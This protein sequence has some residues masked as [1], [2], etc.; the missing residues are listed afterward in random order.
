MKEIILMNAEYN[1]WANRK[2]SDLLK[3]ETEEFLTKEIKSSFPSIY[4]TLFHIWDAEFIWLE[5]LKGNPIAEWPG[6]TPGAKFSFEKMLANSGL[7][8]KHVQS[9]DE[10]YFGAKTRYKNIRGEEF[11]NTNYGILAH[12]FNHSTFHRGQ[13]V[14][15]LRAENFG[16]KIDSTD[17][18]TFLRETK[19]S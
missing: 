6:K 15:M 8:A 13:I 4:K 9:A 1:M 11:E 2:F 3:N 14:T 16:G 7:L 17:L 12:V 10:N 5:R 18:I 19:R